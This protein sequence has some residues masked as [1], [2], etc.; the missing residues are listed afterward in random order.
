MSPIRL[1]SSPFEVSKAAATPR[2]VVDKARLIDALRCCGV[3]STFPSWRIGEAAD[4]SMRGQSATIGWV[5]EVL[6]RSLETVKLP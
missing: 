6:V 4:R 1:S 3:G 2:L 5:G